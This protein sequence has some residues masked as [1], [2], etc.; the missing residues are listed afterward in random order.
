[1]L[2]PKATI[3]IK[4]G[5]ESALR[6]ANYDD[7][8]C[9]MARQ[10]DLLIL[11]TFSSLNV[12]NLLYYQAELANLENELREIESE[13]Q[14]CGVSPRQEYGA[15]WKKLSVGPE[16]HSFALPTSPVRNPRDALQ[17]HLF[18]RIRVVLQE[19]SKHFAP[20]ADHAPHPDF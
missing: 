14:W 7:L 20:L 9:L 13:D 16:V 6:M 10:N 1:M 12:K 17:W 11:R 3:D 4:F 18:C 5:I 8:S 19:Y 2:L 15:S